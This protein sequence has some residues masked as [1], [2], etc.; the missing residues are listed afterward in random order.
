MLCKLF[1]CVPDLVFV[2]FSLIILFVTVS[3]FG[4]IMITTLIICTIF[5]I[6][7]VII[8][9]STVIFMIS[10]ISH[11]IIHAVMTLLLF[12]SLM[13]VMSFFVVRFCILLLKNCEGQ[14][15]KREL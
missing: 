13:F 6:S 15:F 11:F 7:T 5:M 10:T 12:R 14:S 9:I 2:L 3:G 4:D 1:S 8:L